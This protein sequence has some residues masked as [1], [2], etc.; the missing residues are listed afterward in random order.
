MPAFWMGVT[1]LG[2]VLVHESHGLE[3][4]PIHLGLGK[5]AFYLGWI[6]IWISPVC[7]FLTYLGAQFGRAEVISLAAGTAWLWLVDT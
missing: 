7:A 2:G 3:V 6:L 1:A 4:L 5:H